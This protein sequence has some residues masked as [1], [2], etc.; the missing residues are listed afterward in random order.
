[1]RAE[2]AAQWSAAYGG[3]VRDDQVAITQGCNQAFTAITATLAG[4]TRASPYSVAAPAIPTTQP[5]SGS[6]A[7]ARARRSGD[8]ATQAGTGTRVK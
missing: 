3:T 4:S 5:T 6:H 7:A 1:M 2:I 8:H